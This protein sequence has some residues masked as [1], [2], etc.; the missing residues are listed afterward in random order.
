[1]RFLWS[2]KLEKNTGNKLAAI[3][4][5]SLLVVGQVV[6]ATSPI[7]HVHTALGVSTY[8]TYMGEDMGF[9]QYV[10]VALPVGVLC[11]AAWFLLCRFVLKPDVSALKDFNHEQLLSELPPFSKWEKAAGIVYLLV[12]LFWL[13]PGLSQY[14]IPSLYASLK[15]IQQCFPPMAALIVLHLWRVDGEPVLIFRMPLRPP[16]WTHTSFSPPSCSCPV[17]LPTRLLVSPLGCPMF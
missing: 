5:M 13:L 17:A 15:N 8:A 1:M 9:F 7:S 2:L 4:I 10:G 3:I 14:L 6:E 16:R 12:V 11:A